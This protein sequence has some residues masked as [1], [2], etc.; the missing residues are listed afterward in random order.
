MRMKPRIKLL[1][2][3][4]L[5]SALSCE[6]LIKVCNQAFSLGVSFTRLV[7]LDVLGY[8]ATG[9]FHCVFAHEGERRKKAPSLF[10]GS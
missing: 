3:R 8:H 10:C 7:L 6:N 2:K 1:E 4:V 9:S 5:G